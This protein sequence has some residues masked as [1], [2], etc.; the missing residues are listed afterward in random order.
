MTVATLLLSSSHK[1]PVTTVGIFQ[2]AGVSVKTHIWAPPI[3]DLEASPPARSSDEI[4]KSAKGDSFRPSCWA[5]RL[6]RQGCYISGM[7]N[8]EIWTLGLLSTTRRL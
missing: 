5:S 6:L 3:C 8:D 4:Q 7:G 2:A 1:S